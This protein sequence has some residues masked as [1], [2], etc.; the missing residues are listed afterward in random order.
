MKLSDQ[1]LF[2]LVLTINKA[3][4]DRVYKDSWLSQVFKNVDQ[5][6]I[7]SQQTDFMVGA[8][9]GPNVY[10]GRSPKDAHPH[11][12]VDEEMWAL[13]EKFLVE[14]FKETKTPEWLQ[15]KWLKIDNAFKAKILKN[16]FQDCEKRYTLDEIIYVPNPSKN[17]RTG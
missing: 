3:F 9:G 10:K 8:L 14:A 17:Q 12:F 7:E 5:K 11:I 16:S 2:D 1:E 6:L 13:R 4:Y 15:E